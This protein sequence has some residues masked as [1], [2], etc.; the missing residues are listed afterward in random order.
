MRESFNR[1]NRGIPFI[2]TGDHKEI[3]LILLLRK[4]K[5]SNYFVG[6]II[7][8]LLFKLKLYHPK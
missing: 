2:S 4:I 1:H 7:T 8:L 3:S 6:T 5:H